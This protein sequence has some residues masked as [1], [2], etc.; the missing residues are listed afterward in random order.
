MFQQLD[1]DTRVAETLKMTKAKRRRSGRGILPIYDSY[2]MIGEMRIHKSDYEADT[3]RKACQISAE[4]HIEVL[5]ATKPGLNERALQGI[6]I[7]EIMARG[8]SREGYGCIVA[9]G[10]NAT[11]LHYVFN[12]Q[13][14]KDGELLLIDAGAEFDYYTGDITRTYPI[15]GKFTPVQRRLYQQILEVQ[16]HLCK[17]VAPGL[18]LGDMQDAAIDGLIDIMINE[19]LLKGSRGEIRENGSFKKYYP[20]GV[21]H[22]LGSDVHD[23]GMVEVNGQSRVLEPGMSLTVEPG[24]Y[25]PYDD[26]D[27][28]AELRGIGIR[29]EDDVLVTVDGR[30]VMTEG[31]PKEI[32]E[33]ER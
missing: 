16:K 1:V 17:K 19:K 10:A 21:S 23:A 27:A 26:A 18:P 14:L 30:E 5:K 4:A 28:P 33:L 9:G 2:Q 24:L 31:A 12:D 6:F 11:T 13:V 22:L 8:S 15:N 25:I 32:S 7:K 29:I 20:H 3:L